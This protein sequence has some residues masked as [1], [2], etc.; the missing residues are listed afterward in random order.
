MSRVGLLTIHG[1]PRALDETMNDG[2]GLGC[3][4]PSFVVGE[5]VQSLQNRLGI[6]L[7]ENLLYKFDCD[8]LSRVTRSIY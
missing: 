4:S 5:S 7:S 2:K 8:A 1:H 6:F 3:G